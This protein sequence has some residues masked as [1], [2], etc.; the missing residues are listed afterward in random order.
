MQSFSLILLALASVSSARSVSGGEY[1]RNIL[2]ATAMANSSFYPPIPV[3]KNSA[4]FVPDV[5]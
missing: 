2:N 3:N 1:R 4:D 5:T